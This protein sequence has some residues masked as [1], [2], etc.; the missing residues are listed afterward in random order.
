MANANSTVV[1]DS[2]RVD[3]V[4]AAE[5]NASYCVMRC[6][7][8]ARFDS[9]DHAAFLVDLLMQGQADGMGVRHG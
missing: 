6:E 4:P 5:G 3:I 8:V 1:P 7:Q 9:E 2:Y